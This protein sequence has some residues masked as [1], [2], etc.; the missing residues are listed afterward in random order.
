MAHC[1]VTVNLESVDKA[2]KKVEQLISLL[3]EAKEI[4]DS[5]K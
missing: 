4:I 1:T 5:L 2:I 3:K